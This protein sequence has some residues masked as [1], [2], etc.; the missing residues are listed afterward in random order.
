[1]SRFRAL[2]VSGELMNHLCGGDTAKDEGAIDP[3]WMAGVRTERHGGSLRDSPMI[4]QYDRVHPSLGGSLCVLDGL[5]P[6]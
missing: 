4:R 1:M 2:R 3:R 5:D 6:F